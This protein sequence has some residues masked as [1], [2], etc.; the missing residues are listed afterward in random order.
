MTFLLCE[1]KFCY[2]NALVKKIAFN[3]QKYAII[4]N[5]IFKTFLSLKQ[6]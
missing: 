2:F 4:L 1:A 5:N 6:I 3:S